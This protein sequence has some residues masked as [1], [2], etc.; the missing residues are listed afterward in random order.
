MM[1]MRMA[2]PRL[3]AGRGWLQR[4]PLSTQESRDLL[5]D[6]DRRHG[7]S[8]TYHAE[9]DL[10]A[11]DGRP[12]VLMIGWLN[13]RQKHLKRYTDLLYNPLG[14]D[15][16]TML[17]R[18]NH[19]L[20]PSHSRA[21]AAAVAELITGPMAQGRP[22]LIHGFSVGGFIWGCT[23]MHLKDNDM[24]QKAQENLRGVVLDSPVDIE[25]IPY[26]MSSASFTNPA[27]VALMTALLQGVLALNRPALRLYHQS[28]TTFK[29]NPLALPQLVIFS[30]FDPI[31]DADRI[32]QVMTGWE[33]QGHDVTRCIFDDSEHVM[34]M[35]RYFD[36][37]KRALENFVLPKFAST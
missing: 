36:D 32:E 22:I 23:Q 4:A 11:N 26:G 20:L 21:A 8:F 13:S 27:A 17:P 1:L 10:A 5:L 15:V 7:Q 30:H 37:Y 24:I 14:M 29:Q 35:R 16:I 33:S 34:H 25:G 2:R 12:L 3:A 18:P 31:T 28:S 19:V 6:I 9:Q